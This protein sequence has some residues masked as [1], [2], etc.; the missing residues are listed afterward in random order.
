MKCNLCPRNCM[1]DRNE[2]D[3]FG[4]CKMPDKI[5]VGRIAPHFWEEPCI[6]G[7]RGT[8]AVFFSGCTLR[9]VFCQNG[10]IS[11]NGYGKEISVKELE[12]QIRTLENS[13]VHNISL[14]TGTHFVHKIKEALKI[15]RPT[16]PIV[17]NSSGYEKVETLKELEGFVDIFLPDF[18][19][20]DNA[21]A[22]KYSGCSNYAETTLFAIDEMIRQVGTPVFSRD[23]MLQK[24][25]I[26]RHLILPNHTKDSIEV[27]KT[28]KENFGD[29][30]LFSLMGQYVPSN[31]A[32]DY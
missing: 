30:V 2:N 5:K 20:S 1:G 17:W 31:K 29:K 28:V 7:K 10:E 21:L 3:G 32:K 23:G 25:V 12:A 19:Y 27:I 15:Y 4:F 16:I 13:G 8:G 22:K 26:I 18:K 9:C 24:G 11:S 6:S 14:I